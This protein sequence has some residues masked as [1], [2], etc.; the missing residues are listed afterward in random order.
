MLRLCLANVWLEPFPQELRCGLRMGFAMA[1]A[2]TFR[3]LGPLPIL[4]RRGLSVLNN[5][6]TQASL[7]SQP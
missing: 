2:L 6:H 7:G 5:V 4:S 3:A 1:S